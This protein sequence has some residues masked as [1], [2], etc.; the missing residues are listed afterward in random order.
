MN[1]KGLAF[2]AGEGVLL[3]EVWVEIEIPLKGSDMDVVKLLCHLFASGQPT[4][5]L[6]KLPPRLRECGAKVP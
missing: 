6:F 3:V 1:S 5:P 4:K 2:F